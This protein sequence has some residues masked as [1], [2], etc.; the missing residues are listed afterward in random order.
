MTSPTRQWGPLPRTLG[1][2]TAKRT[3]A[4]KSSPAGPRA[5]RREAVP[6]DGRAQRSYPHQPGPPSTHGVRLINP[7]CSIK[8]SET[9]HLRAV[10][11]SGDLDA[12]WQFHI[13]RD[14][15][16]LYRRDEWQLVLK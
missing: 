7:A 6:L 14:Q 12:Y 10:Y 8:D 4:V 9:L 11:L 2:P 1:K 3:A 13:K 5:A 15:Q 16:R